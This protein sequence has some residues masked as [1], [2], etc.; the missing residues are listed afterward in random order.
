[1]LPESADNPTLGFPRPYGQPEP[2]CRRSWWTSWTSVLAAIVFH[3]DQFPVPRQQRL[4]RHDCRDLRQ[5]FPA[6]PFGF[7]CQPA[8]LIIAKT[9]ATVADLLPQRNTIPRRLR[10]CPQR[11]FPGS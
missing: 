4:R 8:T 2:K 6:E 10:Q 7:H 1:M 11:F 9:H 5:D 3:S